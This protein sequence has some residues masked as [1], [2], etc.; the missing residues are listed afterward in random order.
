MPSTAPTGTTP[1]R[2]T[3]GPYADLI[4]G[5]EDVD[6]YEA[7]FKQAARHLIAKDICTPKDFVD[8]GGWRKS[9]KGRPTYVTFCRERSRRGQTGFY[10]TNENERISLNVRTWTTKAR[11]FGATPRWHSSFARMAQLPPAICRWT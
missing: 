10:A 6:R 4:A 3:R 2:N 8:W 7:Q 1:C 9:P 11:S 5:S